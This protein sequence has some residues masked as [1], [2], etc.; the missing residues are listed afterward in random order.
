MTENLANELEAAILLYRGDYLEDLD[1]QW[2][3]PVQEEL[4]NLNIELKQKL[5]VYYLKNKMYSR[6]VTHLHQLTALKPY[7]E[8]VLRLLLTAFAEM[9]DQSAVKKQYTVFS[10]TI[11]EELGLQPSSEVSA[12]YK[13]ICA[14]N[15]S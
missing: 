11:S 14:I 13:K 10:Q 6:A 9:G 7:S 2:V 1:Y 12:F 3:I 15:G 4:R 8:E 5:A